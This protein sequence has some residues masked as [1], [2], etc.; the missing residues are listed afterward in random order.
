MD[1]LDKLSTE[2]INPDTL[3]LDI[4]NV[5]EIIKI[6]N[7]EDKK[8][9]AAVEEVIP[10]ISQAVKKIK[11]RW[12]K[13]GRI[14]YIGAGTSGRLGVLDAAENPST[15]GTDP[16]RIIGIL[17]GGDIGMRSPIEGVEDNFEQGYKDLESINLN[18]NDSV[19]GI[20]ASGRTPYVFGAFK[21]CE[22]V[23]ALKI[24]IACNKEAKLK[25]IVDVAILPETGP[26]VIMG[27]TRM[28]AGT[29]QKM[30]LNMISTTLMVISGKVYKNLM[31]DMQ[32]VNEKLR[33]RTERMVSIACNVDIEEARR[34]LC[35]AD[36]NVKIAI[37]INNGL[38]KEEANVGLKK[39]SG[40]VRRVLDD[41]L[42]NKNQLY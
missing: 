22:E 9:A 19:I 29:A 35:E 13:E 20:T 16:S 24:G 40:I 12:D 25:D 37:L 34:L 14:I 28:K 36:G 33:Y 23:G 3:D 7:E 30:V 26:E 2:S 11:A 32:K 15:F 21:K 38:T 17:A 4:L 6:I 41:K 31:V 8:V 42:H 27:S 18:E 39:Y 5:D 1:K 10:Q